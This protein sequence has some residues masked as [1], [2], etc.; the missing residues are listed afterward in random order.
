VVDPVVVTGGTGVLGRH[1]VDRLLAAGCPVRV[2]SR[3]PEPRP[4]PHPRPTGH[5]VQAQPEPRS[6]PTRGRGPSESRPTTARQWATADLL[7][8]AGVPAAVRGAAVV[9]H[10]ATAFGGTHEVT[11]LRTLLAATAPARPHL[12][13][14]SIAGVD[15]IPFGYYRAKLAAER[16]V[17]RSGL[18]FTILR[19]TQFHDLVRILFAGAVRLPVMPVPDVRFQPVDAGDVAA[20]LV[21]LARGEPVGRVELMG[22]PEVLTAVTLAR[23]YLHAVGRRRRVVPFALPG[24]AFR[25]FRDGGNLVPDHATGQTTFAEYLTRHADPLSFTYRRAGRPDRPRSRGG[26]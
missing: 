18:P 22:G 13:Y 12:V 16:V 25:G 9:V 3:R 14:V 8:G 1:V 5:L 2:V 7:T 17:E 15:R 21:E 11:A 19:A 10:C 24:K 6:D 20:R 23:Q 4:E 26:R